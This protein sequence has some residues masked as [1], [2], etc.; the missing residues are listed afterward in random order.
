MYYIRKAGSKSKQAYSGPLCGKPLVHVSPGEVWK[1]EHSA[2]AAAS[3]LSQVSGIK[4]EVV[5]GEPEPA[6]PVDAPFVG[7]DDHAKGTAGGQPL[8]FIQLDEAQEPGGPI[9]VGQVV[10]VSGEHFH[11]VADQIG[12]PLVIIEVRGG[13]AEET[14]SCPGL[15]K[16]HALIIDW[17]NIEDGGSNDT[18]EDM[19]TWVQEK[20]KTTLELAETWGALVAAKPIECPGCSQMNGHSTKHTPPLCQVEPE[21]AGEVDNG[22]E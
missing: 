13:V 4:F 21:I 3:R 12:H 1:F 19:P 6:L 14:W 15:G 17:D 2:Q 22:D 20:L 8:T 10:A 9:G 11:G 16:P 5:E 7:D 18:L